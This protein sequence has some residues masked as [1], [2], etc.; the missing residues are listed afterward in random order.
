MF[1]PVAHRGKTVDKRIVV[2]SGQSNGVGVP[3]IVQPPDQD[4]IEGITMLNA[5]NQEVPCIHPI[6]F[7]GGSPGFGFGRE[8]AVRIR[9]YTGADVFLVPT[10]EGGS[11][12]SSWEMVGDVSSTRRARA[13]G[14]GAGG[15]L[16]GIRWHH[17]EGRRAEHSA[18]D[19]GSSAPQP[20]G[21]GD[22]DRAGLP[23]LFFVHGADRAGLLARRQFRRQERCA[24]GNVTNSD[25][26]STPTLSR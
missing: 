19:T 20:N 12:L 6:H 1:A 23:N 21:H 15:V 25:L 13:H 17:G 22:V 11:F 8:A 5:L 18:A 10:A 14:P 4:P 16:D 3:P 9:E 26:F 2:V 24:A 7:G